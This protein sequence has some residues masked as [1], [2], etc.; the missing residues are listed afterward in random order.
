LSI[1]GITVFGLRLRRLWQLLMSV[2]GKAP[3]CFDR[4]GHRLKLLFTEVILQTRV[5]RS[6][7]PGLAHAL[8]LYGF[9]AVQVHSS[10]IFIEGMIPA[11]NVSDVSFS[12]GTW[13]PEIYKVYVLIA[14]FLAFGVLLGLGYSLYRRSV[15]KP[16]NLTN[17]MDAKLILLATA[18]IILSFHA[19]NAARLVL[20]AGGS[21]DYG[22]VNK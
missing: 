16:K 13:I 5:R 7:M 14:D 12:Y 15:I 1:V 19:I 22:A 9:L 10:E 20:H 6:L 4:M 21:H 18:V 11:Q 2:E 17:R 8:I 3:Y